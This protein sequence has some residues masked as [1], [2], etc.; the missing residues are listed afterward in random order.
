MELWTGA[1]R[2]IVVDAVGASDSPGAVSRFDTTHRP[3]PTQIYRDSTHVFSLVEAIELSR[4]LNLLPRELLIFGVE[5]QN[6]A[7]GTNVSPA[8]EVGIENM[9]R[10]VMQ[11][12]IAFPDSAQNI[13]API[14]S[15]D[16]KAPG[17]KTSFS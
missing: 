17:P 16:Q 14:W 9:V 5:G 8:V 1:D 12:V 2:V 11:E 10:S 4:A 13:T 7:A 15:Q 6:F 3:L